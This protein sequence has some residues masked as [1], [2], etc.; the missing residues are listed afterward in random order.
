MIKL[1][2]YF[3]EIMFDGDFSKEDVVNELQKRVDEQ[4]PDADLFAY[5][6]KEIEQ[7]KNTDGSY[8]I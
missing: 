4:W 8:G 6:L 5:E 3:G 1:W 2:K 7:N